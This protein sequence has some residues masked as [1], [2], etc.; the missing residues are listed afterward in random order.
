MNISLTGNKEPYQKNKLIKL[1]EI[2]LA[3]QQVN[4]SYLFTLKYNDFIVPMD[5]PT[6]FQVAEG[7]KG[8]FAIDVHFALARLLPNYPEFS[9]SFLM[10]NEIESS[11][12][13]SLFLIYYWIEIAFTDPYAVSLPS[14]IY[15]Q[16]I[17]DSASIPGPQPDIYFL[18]YDRIT[19][20]NQPYIDRLVELNLLAKIS[21][22][23]TPLGENSSYFI[24]LLKPGVSRTNFNNSRDMQGNETYHFW[25]Q[26]LDDRDYRLHSWI[27]NRF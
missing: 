11:L 1:Q 21:F 22:T 27:K 3:V 14:K 7:I 25:K 16:F 9:N 5:A 23:G 26:I 24:P 19:N 20:K 13:K 12:F 2:D 6:F 10:K 4:G 17:L 15:D 8:K 18:R